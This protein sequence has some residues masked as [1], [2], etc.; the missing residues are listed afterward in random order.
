MKNPNP[1]NL[2]TPAE[3]RSRGWQAEARDEDGH[4]YSQHAPFDGDEEL[5]RYVRD[6][7]E[8]GLTVTI[9]PIKK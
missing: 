5:A 9:W 8:S 1:V 3:S 7:V 6:A 4:L 2:M